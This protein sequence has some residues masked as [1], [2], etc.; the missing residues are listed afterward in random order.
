MK[1]DLRLEALTKEAFTPFG[2]V[3]EIADVRHFSIN[4]GSVERY[5]DLANL[6]V[7]EE[8]GRPLV[9]IVCCNDLASLPYTLPLMERH[10]LASQ[11][12]IPMDETPMV[13]AVAEP[14]D[15]LRPQNIRAFISNGQ[16]GV[17]YARGVWHMPMIFLKETQ[18][19]LVIDRGGN[20]HN[21]DEHTFDD[22]EIV[23]A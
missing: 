5:H 16:Q 20:G 11:S 2:D 23:L 9:S 7:L 10:P 3:V 4:Q 18:R 17:N 15:D 1:L 22:W 14:G 12:F 21:L 13:V 6:D 8:G 19:M